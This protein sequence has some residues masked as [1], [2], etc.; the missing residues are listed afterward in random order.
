MSDAT[1]EER[2]GAGSGAGSDAGTGERPGAGSGGRPH[3][4]PQDP[5]ASDI[6]WAAEVRWHD[7]RSASATAVVVVGCAVAAGVCWGTGGRGWERVMAIGLVLSL[8]IAWLNDLTL[9]RAQ[10]RSGYSVRQLAVLQR[11][12]RQERIP[13]DPQARRVM[14]DLIRM[15]IGRKRA[16]GIWRVAVPV[17]LMLVIGV[18]NLLLGHFL[19]GAL[20]LAF[21]GFFVTYYRSM[22][23]ARARLARVEAALADPGQQTT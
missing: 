14:A 6:D 3:E 15:Q 8:F 9:T 10:A 23:S 5:S 20:V 22:A 21:A 1:P 17:C 7:T 2:P 19:L 16:A 18:V 11:R 12:L 4:G 13:A